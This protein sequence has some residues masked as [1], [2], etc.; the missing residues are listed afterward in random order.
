MTIVVLVLCSNCSYCRGSLL[1]D[2]FNAKKRVY[3]EN[4][5]SFDLRENFSLL[6]FNL[7]L[8]KGGIFYDIL[9]APGREQR[10]KKK[11]MLWRIHFL[12]ISLYIHN[13]ES[14]SR[15]WRSLWHGFGDDPRI[16]MTI[17]VVD[18]VLQSG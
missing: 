4:L 13:V 2:A 16:T 3:K 6:W 10:E 9:F 7:L 15:S 17:M 14:M 5:L 8:I 18:I 12:W 1:S 11:R